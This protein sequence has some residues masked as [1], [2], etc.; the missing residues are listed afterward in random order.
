[1]ARNPQHFING[2]GVQRISWFKQC[3]RIRLGMLNVGSLCEKI[4]EVCEE[5]RKRRV[6]VLHAGSKME[7][8]RSSFCGYFVTKV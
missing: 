1:M 8:P 2:Q 5:L 7:R 4:T 3:H 6:D